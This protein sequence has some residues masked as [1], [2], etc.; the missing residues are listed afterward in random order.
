MF[1]KANKIFYHYDRMEAYL[2]GGLVKPI[3]VKMRL[4]DKCNL[5]CYYCS[6]KD[7]LSEDQMTLQDAVKV[8]KVL[9]DMGVKA[10]VLTGGEPTVYPDL[11]KFAKI[12]K[13]DF[14]FELAL[15]TNG[16]IYRDVVKYMTWIRFSLDTVNPE[17]YKKIKGVAALDKVLAT[18]DKT[19]KRKQELNSGCTIGAQAIV[20]PYN[21]DDNFD[22][23]R[24]AIEFSESKKLDYFQIRP[25]ENY[26]YPKLDLLIIKN[27]MREIK[28][29]DYKIKIIT[30]DYKWHEIENGYKKNYKGCPAADFMGSI[31]IKGDFYICCAMINDKTAKYGNLITN[32]AKDILDNRKTVQDNFDY[33]K[34]TVACQGSLLNQTLA[35][36]KNIQHVNFI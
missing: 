27:N 5:R 31:D 24:K 13:E 4:I 28:R 29:T 12:A 16:V 23:I 18:I 8:L 19:M 25:L 30:T 34:C 36:F 9:K 26:K 3:S 15:I 2:N 33:R 21:F 35:D 11:E 1:I 32:S 14:G 6:Y 20:T 22:D 17:I 7:N 10:I